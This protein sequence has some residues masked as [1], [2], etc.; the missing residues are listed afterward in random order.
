VETPEPPR[1]RGAVRL[2]RAAEERGLAAAAWAGRGDQERGFSMLALGLAAA[3]F[4][5]L[6]L[7]WIGDGGHTESGWVV[8]Q[9]SGV[10]ALAVVLV[11]TLRLARAWVSRGSVLLAFC[12]L[13]ATGVLGVESWANT[14]WGVLFGPLGFAIFQYG[15]WIGLVLAILLV[16]VAALRLTVLW[17]SAP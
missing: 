12:L 10:L 13:A 16:A 2:G 11:E 3:Y 8:A 4:I 5:V 6:F 17:R 1:E 7:P 9:D 15:A 14:R